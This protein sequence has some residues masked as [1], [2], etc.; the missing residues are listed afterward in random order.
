MNNLHSGKAKEEEPV[1]S[2]TDI[3]LQS[4]VIERSNKGAVRQQTETF[5]RGAKVVLVLGVEHTSGPGA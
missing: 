3:G 4:F 1:L 2:T 5:L